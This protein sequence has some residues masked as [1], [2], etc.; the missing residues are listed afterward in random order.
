MLHWDSKTLKKLQHSGENG[1]WFAVVLTALHSDKEIL[2]DLINLS[3]C[4][5]EAGSEREAKAIYAR[6]MEL[7]IDPKSIVRFVFDT[8]ATNSGLLNGVVVRLQKL[9]KQEYLQLACRH[10]VLEL[11]SGAS[12]SLVYH[13][14]DKPTTKKGKTK[15]GTESPEE[16]IFKAFAAAWKDV[17]KSDYQTFTPSCREQGD[18][19]QSTI[20]FLLQWLNDE[21]LRHDYKELVELAILFLGGVFPSSTMLV[22]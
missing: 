2:V 17:D 5:G 8:T 7:G 18:M 10:H 9:L 11:V 21:S 19:C 20:V 4:E 15:R 6:L 16:P 12:C 1:D 3:E 13:D 14:N 22:G